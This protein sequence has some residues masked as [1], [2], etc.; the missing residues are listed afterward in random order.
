MTAAA[1]NLIPRARVLIIVNA[2]NGRRA[3][4][5]NGGPVTSQNIGVY[6][7]SVTGDFPGKLKI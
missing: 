1:A 5:V 2:G 4:E 3:R 6:Q 7:S